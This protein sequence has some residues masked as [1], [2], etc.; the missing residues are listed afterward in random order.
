MQ[1]GWSGLFVEAIKREV[2]VFLRDMSYFPEPDLW[3]VFGRSEVL[4]SS[5]PPVGTT[6]ELEDYRYRRVAS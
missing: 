1:E 5:N 3:I 6:K 2:P 4:M